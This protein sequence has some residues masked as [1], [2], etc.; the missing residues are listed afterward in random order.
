MSN[1]I[2]H[3]WITSSCW[4]WINTFWL[5]YLDMFQQNPCHSWW[6]VWFFLSSCYQGLTV[7]P[8]CCFR[9]ERDYELPHPNWFNILMLVW[10]TKKRD[11]FI[12]MKTNT[13][14]S[15]M[16]RF[17]L[18]SLT[19]LV[20]PEYWS[21]CKEKHTAKC[22]LYVWQDQSFVWRNRTNCIGQSEA[23]LLYWSRWPHVSLYTELPSDIKVIDSRRLQ[24]K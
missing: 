16:K 15:L 21:L 14:E 10:T 6:R 24:G 13:I 8:G 2:Q 1:I 12:K 4:T 7:S 23:T 11:K 3:L 5:S 17:L 18:T 20:W 22:F 19:I 9:C